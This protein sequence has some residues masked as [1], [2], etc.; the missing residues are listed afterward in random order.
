[1]PRI[2]VPLN[3]WFRRFRRWPRAVAASCVEIADRLGLPGKVSQFLRIDQNCSRNCGAPALKKPHARA[4]LRTRSL[5]TVKYSRARKDFR[6]HTW[7][8]LPRRAVS[9][10]T[11]AHGW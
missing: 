4:K 8:I 3:R 5:G 7:F 9:K 6:C 10:W 2:M 11:C 1:M